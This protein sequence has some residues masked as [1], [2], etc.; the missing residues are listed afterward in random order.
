MKEVNGRTFKWCQKCGRWST[1]HS[2][3][4]HQSKSQPTTTAKTVQWEDPACWKAQLDDV[5]FMGT[6]ET[7]PSVTPTDWILLFYLFVTFVAFVSM[8][9]KESSNIIGSWNLVWKFHSCH[10]QKFI[11]GCISMLNGEV[12]LFF[13]ILPLLK[14][15]GAP[16]L[17]FGAG[18]TIHH[19]HATDNAP[20]PVD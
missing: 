7:S 18:L 16:I 12:Q 10:F 3:S 6:T 19:L 15:L 8:M 4:T 9:W 14:F 5:N 11:L 20:P 1:T 2:T 13:R 17:Y